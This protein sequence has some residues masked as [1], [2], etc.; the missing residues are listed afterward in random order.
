MKEAVK[1]SSLIIRKVDFYKNI[2]QGMLNDSH[3]YKSIDSNEGK[4]VMNKKLIHTNKY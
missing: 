2:I 4:V 1:A 3:S